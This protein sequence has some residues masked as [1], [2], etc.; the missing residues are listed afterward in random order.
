MV[1]TESAGTA[2]RQV[3]LGGRTQGQQALHIHTSRCCSPT[4]FLFFRGAALQGYKTLYEDTAD[5][6]MEMW[7]EGKETE[8]AKYR[9]GVESVGPLAQRG[10][11]GWYVPKYLTDSVPE[12]A[13][14]TWLTTPAA[15]S[16][17]SASKRVTGSQPQCQNPVFQCAT[18]DTYYPPQ[19]RARNCSL[20]MIHWSPTFSA[21][22]SEQLINNLNLSVNVVYLGGD[23]PSCIWQ[24]YAEREPFLV[25]WWQPDTS[26]AGLSP[27][28]FSRVRLP[29]QNSSCPRPTSS[30]DGPMRCDFSETEL[31]KMVR[32]GVPASVRHLAERFD[33]RCE[34][35]DWIREQAAQDATQRLACQWVKANEDVW[36][37]WVPEMS[38]FAYFMPDEYSNCWCVTGS[39]RHG[40][41]GMSPCFVCCFEQLF[42]LPGRAWAAQCPLVSHSSPKRRQ[43]QHQPL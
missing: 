22:K 5:V 32:A 14:S 23:V 19:C 43:S 38:L 10:Q 11:D 7:N 26:L 20:Q 2:R 13:F 27:S 42:N 29:F 15:L 25:H 36:R 21:A 34:D 28:M 30:L 4:F 1:E 9:H 24:K 33:M 3:W 35:M 8:Y 6:T 41:R 39:K 17:F 12:A 18:D 40:R 37:E 16:R 31:H